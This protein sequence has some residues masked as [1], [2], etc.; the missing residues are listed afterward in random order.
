MIGYYD[1]S[2]YKLLDCTTDAVFKSRDVIFKKSWPHYS[3]DPIVSFS[4]AKIPSNS[5]PTVIAPR[6]KQ[7]TQLHLMPPVST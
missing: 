5:H 1:R 3:T 7:I 4:N 6:P 2:G